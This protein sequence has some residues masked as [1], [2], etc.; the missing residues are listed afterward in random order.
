MERTPE[1]EVAAEK[2][3]DRLMKEPLA[4]ERQEFGKMLM[5]D[6]DSFS[7]EELKRYLE[8]KRILSEVN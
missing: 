6:I 8:L 7:A 5:R 4:K 1:K 2:L 3:L